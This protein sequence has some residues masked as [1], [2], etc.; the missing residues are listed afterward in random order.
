VRLAPIAISAIFQADNKGNK[1]IF[2]TLFGGQ[3]LFGRNG[4][5][6]TLWGKD[7]FASCLVWLLRNLVGRALN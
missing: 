6:L 3:Q 4:I 1:S 2:G 5:H 7:I